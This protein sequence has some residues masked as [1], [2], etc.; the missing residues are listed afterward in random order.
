[1]RRPVL[2]S[3]G[4]TGGHLFP[5]QALGEALRARGVP[6]E[7]VTDTRAARFDA[8][9]PA[10]AVHRI[11]SA[12]PTGAGAASKARAALVLG[13]GTLSALALLKRIDPA[14]VVGFGGYPTVP[15][16]LAAR[17][18]RIPAILHE[19]NAVM[20]RANRLLS[21][22]AMHIATGFPDLGGIAPSLRDRI[23]TRAIPCGP[24]SSWR[25]P[26]P[27]LRRTVCCGCLSPAVRKARA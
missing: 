13:R 20:G 10:R 1:M 23:V 9:F 12:T 17:L 3:A 7:L 5:A 21:A 4:G 26:L 8:S 22:G 24:S 2:L 19:Q 11:A 16:M 25:V 18:L 15:P 14:I 6:V 27:I